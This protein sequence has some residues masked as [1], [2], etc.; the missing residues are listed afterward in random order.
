MAAILNTVMKREQ[1]VRDATDSYNDILEDQTVVTVQ[2]VLRQ[3]KRF[4]LTA[5]SPEMLDG[6]AA[7][8]FWFDESELGELKF[9][10]RNTFP[11]VI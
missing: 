5:K 4:G 7:L 10:R 11:G 8:G 6:E 1:D 3:L 2:K 9:K